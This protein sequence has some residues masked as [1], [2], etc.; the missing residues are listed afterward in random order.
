MWID[1]EERGEERKGMERKEIHALSKNRH[2]LQS[3]VSA[4]T[5]EDWDPNRLHAVQ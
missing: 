5:I 4:V 3:T 2:Y 1:D